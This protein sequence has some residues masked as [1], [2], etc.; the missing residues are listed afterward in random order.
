VPQG[1][2]LI[3]QLGIFPLELAQPISVRLV[4][5]GRRRNRRGDPSRI[6]HRNRGVAYL[7]LS[8]DH[9]LKSRLTRVKQLSHLLALTREPR[10]GR[11]Q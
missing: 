7:S 10:Q 5:T 9:C 11:K 6:V 3:L 1:S 2:H 8:A 4:A